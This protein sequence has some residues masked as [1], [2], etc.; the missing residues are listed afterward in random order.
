M[1]LTIILKNYNNKIDKNGTF[2]GASIEMSRQRVTLAGHSS[3]SRKLYNITKNERGAGMGDGGLVS[4]GVGC[5]GGA[6]DG[7][8]LQHNASDKI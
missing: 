8:K 3:K 1:T 2:D 7:D 6:F 4:E 5:G